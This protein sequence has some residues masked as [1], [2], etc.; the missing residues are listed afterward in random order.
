MASPAIPIA[1]GGLTAASSSIPVTGASRPRTSALV[2]RTVPHHGAVKGA[3]LGLRNP[4]S[5]VRRHVVRVRMPNAV[6][7][8]MR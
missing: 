8:P 1:V 3:V 4:V 2:N 7:R 6:M 5:P